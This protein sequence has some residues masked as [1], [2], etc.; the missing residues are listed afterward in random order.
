[1]LIVLDG[2]GPWHLITAN[3]MHGVFLDETTSLIANGLA[4]FFCLMVLQDRGG[5]AHRLLIGDK[6]N[7]MGGGGSDD[8]TW[9]S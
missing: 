6:R 8:Q 2:P 3:I 1:M 4:V 7:L 9:D 5:A